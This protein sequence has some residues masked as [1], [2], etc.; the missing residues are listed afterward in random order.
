[1]RTSLLGDSLLQDYGFLLR[2]G[3]CGCLLPGLVSSCS[4]EGRWSGS[5]STDV[6]LRGAALTHE[7]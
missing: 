6:H 5:T 3:W 4:R 1:M 2:P 7:C